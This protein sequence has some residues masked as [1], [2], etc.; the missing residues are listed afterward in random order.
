MGTWA[1]SSSKLL[2]ISVY[3][4]QDITVK[5][6]LWGYLCSMIDRWDGECVVLGNF[7]EVRSE[8]ERFGLIDLPLGGYSYTWSHKSASKMS[9]L[10]RFLISEGLMELFPHITGLCLDRH[11]SDHRP[12]IMF[13]SK[14]DYGPIPFRVFHSWFKLEGFDKF[15]EDTWKSLE[16][17]DSNALIYMKKKLQTLKY[18]IKDWVLQNKKIQNER[19]FKIKSKLSEVDKKLDR[20][21]GDN[22]ALNIRILLMKD[23][24]DINSNEALDLAQKAKIR[25]SI[26]GDENSN[27]IMGFSIVKDPNLPFVGFF[28]MAIGL[29]YWDIMGHDIVAAVS[30]FFVSVVRDF[31]PISLIGSIYKIVAKILANR[32][33][34]VILDLIGEVQTA[35][36]SNRQILDGPFILNELISWCKHKKVKAMIFKV[37]FEKAFDSIRWD[38]LD[39]VLK[40]FGFGVKWRSWISG[41]LNSAK[42]S[43]LINGSPTSEFQFHKGLKQ[44][45]PLSPF[46]FILVMESLHRSFNRV[47]EVGLYKGITINNSLT[48][49]HLFYADDAVFVGKWDISNV[50]T[51][52]NVLNCF[53]L[54]SGLKIN[55]HKSKLTGIGVSKE[56]TEFAASIVGCSTCSFPFHYLGAKVGVSM[57][58]IISWKEVIDKISCRLSK[59]KTKTLFIGGRLTLLKSVLTSLPLY[60]MSI[61]KTPV[62]VIKA[63]EAIRRNFFIGSDK[64]ERKMV[65][66]RWDIVLASKKYGGLGVS[67]FYATN[68][69]LL[70]KWLWRFLTQ[71]SS[72]WSN[73]IKAIH[74]DKGD[75][76]LR[77]SHPRLFALEL[78]KD[79]KVA[80]KL[81]LPSLASSFR[82]MPRSGAEQDQYN[83]DFSV[84]SVRNYI[85]GIYLPRLDSPTRWVDLVPIKSNILVWKI[86]MNGLPTRSNLSSRGLDIPSILCPICDETAETTSHT[87]FSCVLAR[88]IMSKVFRWWELDPSSINSYVDW[89]LWLDNMRIAKSKKNV[90]EGVCYV[91]WWLLWKFGNQSLFGA[92]KPRKDLIFDDIIQLS[93][94]W[95]SNRCKYK[96]DWGTWITNP[97]SITF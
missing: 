6:S 88:D 79:I 94:L 1:P 78:Q 60:Y 14:L 4:P 84:I 54:A 85:D 24:S 51:I 52:V 90:L 81:N 45:D 71:C 31:R 72:L 41:C 59:W 32:L 12:I 66:N 35:F 70:F 42:G 53:F 55:L 65:W 17:S 69:A 33:S 16:V 43:V 91:S 5:R 64:T 40:S 13:E 86:C 44:G 97:N 15:V 75:S 87:F 21:E 10:D 30:Q 2:V 11:L 96:I 77:K 68:R 93:Y 62:A 73:L 37:D 63:L 27:I 8:Q 29:K 46:L 20:G 26:E 36:V 61:Y 95:I 18:V 34:V 89:L 25:W 7:N 92:S 56:D 38:Y 9:K 76:N 3:A 19:K 22:E 50:K 82:R 48:L 39:N 80:D 28:L 57:S 23:L 83:S 49:S 67:S 58:R 47:I 74:G